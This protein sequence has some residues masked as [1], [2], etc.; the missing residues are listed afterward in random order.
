TNASTAATLIYAIGARITAAAGTRLALQLFLSECFKF[1]QL[2][3][4]NRNLTLLCQVTTYPCRD[5][6]ICAP[7]AF[8]RYGSCLSSS[9]YRVQAHFS[10]TRQLQQR[11]LSY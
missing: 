6:V 9:L 7:A 4:T 1:R 8:L 5:W 3:S 2:Q 11:P 10:M